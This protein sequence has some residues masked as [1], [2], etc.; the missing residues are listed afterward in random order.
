MKFL[1]VI[2]SI[3]IVGLF[4]LTAVTQKIPPASIGV[5]QVVFGPGKG[6]VQEDFR[7]GLVLAIPSY[8][9]WHHRGQYRRPRFLPLRHYLDRRQGSRYLG[10]LEQSQ[11]SHQQKSSPHHRHRDWRGWFWRCISNR[12]S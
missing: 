2:L 11:P 4:L 9:R 8:H 10:H 5:K 12:H 3:L 7:T 6:V 1:S